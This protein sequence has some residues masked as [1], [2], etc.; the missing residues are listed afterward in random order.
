[1]SDMMDPRPQLHR[2]VGK[3][4]KRMRE[5]IGLTTM[6]VADDLNLMRNVIIRWEN[7]RFTKDVAMY[8]D[9]IYENTKHYKQGTVPMYFI[10]YYF[11]EE[12]QERLRYYKTIGY[13]F[14]YMRRKVL[15]KGVCRMAKESGIGAHIIEDIERNVYVDK[16]IMRQYA[17]YIYK[18]SGPACN[19]KV[20]KIA[21][22]IYK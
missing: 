21:N 22:E 17:N 3:C 9:Y 15:D 4:L 1:M 6:E 10:D 11:S 7:G 13:A 18:M 14:Y 8:V 16:Y 2:R 12:I 19:H 20:L 5:L